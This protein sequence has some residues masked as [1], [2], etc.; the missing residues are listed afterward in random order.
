[1]AAQ[2]RE[3]AAR[4]SLKMKSKPHASESL[5]Q[6]VTIVIGLMVIA[7][8]IAWVALILHRG[9][10]YD[11]VQR[12]HSIWMA[13]EGLRPYE[14]FFESHPPYFALLSPLARTWTDPG[15]LLPALRWIAAG[16]NLLFL[17][18][19][20]AISAIA[21][22]GGGRRAAI[23][24]T[25]LV[26][27]HP[28]V[29]NFLAEF[30]IDGWGYALATWS[31]VW[32][33]RSQG[34]WRAM[35]LGLGA[36]LATLFLCP[37]LALLPP[38]LVAFDQL[39]A[40]HSLKEVSRS[41]GAYAG[42][43]I[44]AGGIFWLWLAAN[45]V[46]V[47][48]AFACLVRYNSL[49]NAHSGFGF[50]LLRSI[51]SYPALSLPILVA[52]FTWAICC[53]R[54][55]SVAT[56]YLA[57][58]A[59]WLGLQAMLVSYPYK[60]YYGPW[61]LFASGFLPVLRLWL[62][63]FP[64][65]LQNGACCLLG[66]IS[67]TTSLMTAQ[68]WAKATESR[69]HEAFLRVMNQISKPPDRIVARPPF[70]P[71]YRRDTFYAW[72][73]TIDPAGFETEEVFERIPALRDLVSERRYRTE[74]NAHPPAL[75]VLAESSAYP[76]RQLAVLK[77]FLEERKYVSAAIGKVVVA[78]RPDRVRTTPPRINDPSLEKQ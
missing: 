31:M 48:L 29:L 73:N 51:A 42:G 58:L 49:S 60:Q 71:I 72:F 47:D 77:M 41:L 32:F 1:V 15:D 16:G 17:A 38:M 25:A 20:A 33:R 53:I 70:H 67:V 11:E 8:G 10:D 43:A 34:R 39:L 40:P 63:T 21:G 28:A 57:A 61:I 26:A 22:G 62:K 50:G 18:G 69:N 65:D 7:G 75:V 3:I 23:L 19:L 45:G 52:L 30:R 6:L 54:A 37:K 27:F 12:A 56:A 36:S 68:S 35:G 2:L 9:Y 46:S 55:K 13:S 59:L 24:V 78:V 4:A 44:L 64:K 74:L 14:D 66:A 5:N 76:R